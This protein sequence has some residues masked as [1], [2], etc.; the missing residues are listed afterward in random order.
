MATSQTAVDRFNEAIQS[1]DE[2]LQGLREQFDDRRKEFETDLRKRADK[3]QSEVQKSALYKRA[4]Q[5]RKEVTD[6]VDKARES[7]YDVFGIASKADV[8]KLNRKLSS[9]SRKLNDLSKEGG[10]EEARV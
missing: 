4:T 7:L 5:A 2:Q 6:Q 1:L 10:K 8:D 3:V 9:I